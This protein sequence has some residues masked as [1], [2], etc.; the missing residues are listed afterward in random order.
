MEL[1]TVITNLQTELKAFIGKQDD[2][3]KAAGQVQLDTKNAIATLQSRIEELDK[4][5]CAK[6]MTQETKS[7]VDT[8]KEN[9]SLQKL[10]R[11][12]ATKCRFEISG[13]HAY[14]ILERKT[15][16]T[17]ATVG[18][19]TSGV[20]PEERGSFVAEA[21]RA[22]RI[23][24]IIPRRATALG[25]IYWPKTNAK[26]SDASPQTSQGAS[27]LENA[28]TFTTAN[29]E[30]QTI[31]T[32]IPAAKQVL[33]DWS[34]LAGILTNSLSYYTN[35]EVDEQLLSG[36]NT[37]GS[38]Y[39][40]TSQAQ[41]FDTSLLPAAALGYTYIDTIA[42]AFEQVDADDELPSDYVVLSTTDVWNLRKTKDGEG[43]YMLQNPQDN[44]AFTLWGRRVV[45]SNSMTVGYFLAGSAA[46]AAAEIRDRMGITIDISTEHSDFFTKNLVA[47]R[48]ETR[49]ALCVYRPN[50]FVYGALATSPA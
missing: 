27:K 6:A 20:M 17:S 36:D 16:I 38:L 35:K 24:E 1:E 44:A 40:L 39:G 12:E 34:E 43:R 19:P 18:F 22:L 15:T 3:M 14:D 30:V 49:L 29:A 25:K 28:M 50:A 23:A 8:L 48:A 26:M 9:D 47:I 4:K 42:S 10:V 31:A 2:E 5:L 45:P 37:N 21:R 33:D 7:F 46:S 32:W 13:K 41:S 11:G